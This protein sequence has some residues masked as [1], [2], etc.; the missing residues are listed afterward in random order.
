MNNEQRS[1]F[2]R[3]TVTQAAGGTELAEDR[4]RKLAYDLILALKGTDSAEHAINTAV[5]VLKRAAFNTFREGITLADQSVVEQLAI[6][7][8]AVEEVGKAADFHAGACDLNEGRVRDLRRQVEDLANDRA[9]ADA[10][11]KQLREELKQAASVA[12]ENARMR[13]QLHRIV[14]T[15]ESCER[16]AGDVPRSTVDIVDR[17]LV[18]HEFGQA[19]KQRLDAAEAQLRQA[20]T[21]A[22]DELAE[23]HRDVDEANRNIKALNEEVEQL[24][25]LRNRRVAENAPEM[26][27]Y[28]RLHERDLLAAV[29]LRPGE[30]LLVLQPFG[31]HIDGQH[32][33]NAA[34]HFER[35]S[36]CKEHRWEVVDELGPYI[37]IVRPEVKA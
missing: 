18:A 6:A 16:A 27:A 33:P 32:I 15:L 3:M 10:E 26:L 35:E 5:D 4:L 17:I 21:R 7:L 36:V 28:E 37:A 29:R 30:R 13:G 23:A 34:E 22:V 19:M 24:R 20:H 9:A 1:A 12:V 31:W 8:E 14:T 2:E 11:A 25:D